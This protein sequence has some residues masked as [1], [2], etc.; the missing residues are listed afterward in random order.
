V[1]VTHEPSIAARCQRTITITAGR[2][3]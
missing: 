1:L 3:V 2:L